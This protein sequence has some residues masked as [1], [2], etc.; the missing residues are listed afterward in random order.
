M[1]R[2][3]RYDAIDAYTL[4]ELSREYEAADVRGRIHLLRRIQKILKSGC[5]PYEIAV[6]AVGDRHVQVR[7]WIARHGE[8]LD[9]RESKLVD[10][11]LTYT[12]PER[13]FEER[14]KNDPDP[15][16]RASLHENPILSPLAWTDFGE[17]FQRASHLE[18][19][20]LVRNPKADERFIENIFDNEDKELA[21]SMDERKELILAYLTNEDMV[22][23]A[24][25]RTREIPIDEYL[26]LSAV[27]ADNHFSRL[28]EL[29]SKWPGESGIPHAV[30]SFVNAPDST[31]AKVYQGCEKP[32]FRR[33]ILYGCTHRD[34][35]TLKLGVADA[36]AECREVAAQVMKGDERESPEEKFREEV[37]NELSRASQTID[38]LRNWVMVLAMGVFFM[39]LTYLLPRLLK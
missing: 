27:D 3:T 26:I 1:E 2:L 29:A 12:H 25:L 28:W 23:K 7:A 39:V 5:I 4:E 38:S 31:K 24:K 18:R 10:G 30:Y 13:N 8:I 35:E 9:Y 17:W 11:K 14:L 15:F 16:V 21:L 32:F 37:H 22:F 20:A 6:L 19:L 34:K 36:D 33:T